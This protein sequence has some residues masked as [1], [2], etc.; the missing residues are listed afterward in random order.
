MVDLGEEE[1]PA[2]F[3]VLYSLRQILDL[4]LGLARIVEEADSWIKE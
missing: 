3:V 4:V 1:N 2:V